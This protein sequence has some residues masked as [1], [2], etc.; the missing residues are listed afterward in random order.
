MNTV[1]NNTVNVVNNSKF[2]VP[3]RYLQATLLTDTI[4][5]YFYM[6]NERHV[7]M[8]VNNPNQMAKLY[9]GIV[10]YISMAVPRF[11]TIFIAK[12]AMERYL[13]IKNSHDLTKL[14]AGN[15]KLLNK[16]GYATGFLTGVK[17]KETKE[18]IKHIKIYKR[19]S[20]IKDVT[21]ALVIR[22]QFG[23]FEPRYF[24]L[25]GSTSD[26]HKISSLKMA[27]KEET[28]CPFFQARPI[29]MS[30]WIN[31]PDDQK[32]ATCMK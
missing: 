23:N 1:T 3:G 15:G 13:E 10:T 27:Y 2:F 12:D 25:T 19:A 16:C 31:L 5:R 14:L 17:T 11:S 9:A 21:R 26:V 22:S 32:Q 18:H 24:Q 20:S 30:T 29:L 28:G 6:L 8:S 7:K 4:K